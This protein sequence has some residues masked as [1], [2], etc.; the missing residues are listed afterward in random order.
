MGSGIPAQ[1]RR[2][3]IWL[4]GCHKGFLV[5]A[6]N[7]LLQ[8]VGDLSCIGL[9]KNQVYANAQNDFEYYNQRYTFS[10]QKETWTNDELIG[11]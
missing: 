9:K 4:E 8:K 11:Q 10:Q 1:R 2:N 3:W 5:H 6:V 7:S